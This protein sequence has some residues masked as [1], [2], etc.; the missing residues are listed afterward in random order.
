MFT[1]RSEVVCRPSVVN[2]FLI[3]VLAKTF[4]EEGASNFRTSCKYTQISCIILYEII[5][6]RIDYTIF[7][8]GRLRKR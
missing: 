3:K 2:V 7:A 5:T 4:L 1:I 8:E 6:V